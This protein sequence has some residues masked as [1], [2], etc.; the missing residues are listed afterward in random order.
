V[1]ELHLPSD[2]RF[3]AKWLPTFC[4][5]RVPRGQHHGSLP[6]YSRF[7]RQEP[8]HFYQ[9]AP[10]LYSRSWVD[11]V[12]DPLL[13]FCSGSAGNRTRASGFVVKNSD[14]CT[15]EAVRWHQ[16]PLKFV[17]FEIRGKTCIS[18]FHSTQPLYC[19]RG[20]PW[21]SPAIPII[22]H[23]CVGMGLLS[24]ER[25]SLWRSAFPASL[26]IT[27]IVWIIWHMYHS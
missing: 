16:R 11:P 2:L 14:H 21:F 19:V 9:V 7:S 13:L 18:K 6:P 5:Y 27:R 24:S 10:Q 26:P 23:S 3:S 1:S 25:K 20:A 8:L 15:T 12:P 4:G 22:V 17:T